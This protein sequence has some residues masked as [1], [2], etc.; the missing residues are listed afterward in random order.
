MSSATDGAPGCEVMNACIIC[1]HIISIAV[2][3]NGAPACEGGVPDNDDELAG[4]SNFLTF[5]LELRTGVTSFTARAR[6]NFSSS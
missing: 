1:L 3:S 2:L 5:L 6:I 4:L